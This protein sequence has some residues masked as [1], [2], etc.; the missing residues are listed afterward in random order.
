MRRERSKQR[1]SHSNVGF[2]FDTRH[3]GANFISNF[4]ILVSEKSTLMK[5]TRPAPRANESRKKVCLLAHAGAAVT[6]SVPLQV[7]RFKAGLQR[8]DER[9]VERE[10]KRKK[11]GIDKKNMFQVPTK[12]TAL[13]ESSSTSSLSSHLHRSCQRCW[14]PQAPV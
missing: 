8:S 4:F 9:K 14:P 11:Q 13:Q 1:D 6:P 5:K 2:P 7:E 3:F 10:R 12:T